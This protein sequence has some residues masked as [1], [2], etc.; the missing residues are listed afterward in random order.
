M[1]IGRHKT[2]Q[3]LRDAV[4]IMARCGGISEISGTRLARRRR[5]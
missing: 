2:G 3:K 5:Q 4:I 1:P